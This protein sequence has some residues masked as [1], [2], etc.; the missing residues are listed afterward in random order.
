MEAIFDILCSHGFGVFD[1]IDPQDKDKSDTSLNLDHHRSFAKNDQSEDSEM[2]SDED[3]EDE[4]DDDG[5][6]EDKQEKETFNE[7]EESQAQ[8]QEEIDANFN[9]FLTRFFIFLLESHEDI[10]KLTA[11]KGIGK[12]MLF[13][14]LQSQIL[15]S[16]LVLMWYDNESNAE[17]KE[18]LGLFLP[19]FAQ[20]NIHGIKG[21]VSFEDCFIPLIEQVFYDK[22]EYVPM[23]NMINFLSDLTSDE[24]HSRLVLSISNKILTQTFN[25]DISSHL[26]YALTQMRLDKMEKRRLKEFKILINQMKNDVQQVKEGA[27]KKKLFDSISKIGKKIDYY[28]DKLAKDNANSSHLD[29]SFKI[30]NDI[31]PSSTQPNATQLVDSHSGDTQTGDTE[32][33]SIR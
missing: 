13:G 10:I 7:V 4:N 25:N 19:F 30:P 14:R 18:Y 12:L 28:L 20:H 24:V 16:K 22:I 9:Q 15:F 21:Q 33:N 26:V 6:D 23:E 31:Q 3:T 5:N 32:S 17:L 8:S 2:K 11:S 27:K 29:D 1:D